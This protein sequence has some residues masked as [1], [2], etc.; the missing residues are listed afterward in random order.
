MN[1]TV[2]F[3]VA[4][5]GALASLLGLSVAVALR[6]WWIAVGAAVALVAFAGVAGLFA[7]AVF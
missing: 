1:S 5:A 4:V 6:E 2:M 7:G 3:G